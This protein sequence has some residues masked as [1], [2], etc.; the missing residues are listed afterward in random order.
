MRK[1]HPV[2]PPVART[3][4][5]LAQ[6]DLRRGGVDRAHHRVSARV[7]AGGCGCGC[8]CGGGCGAGIGGRGGAGIGGSGCGG[9]GIG[10]GGG[11]GRGEP[12][13]DVEVCQADVAGL[14]YLVR[15]RVRVR[16]RV[17]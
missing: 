11:A 12:L 10:S 5:A 9:A 17:G 1:E 4:P 2:R 3:R 16:V 13:G 7:V 8:G 14:V 15:V 6:Q